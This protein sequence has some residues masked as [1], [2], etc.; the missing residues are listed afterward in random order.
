MLPH[1]SG[2][3]VFAFSAIARNDEFIRSV[4]QL[5]GE[6]VGNKSFT[7]HYHYLREDH[8]T[9]DEMAK[10]TGASVIA[11]TAK[12]LV[13][14]EPGTRFSLDLFV[15]DVAIQFARSDFIDYLF[16]ILTN[17]IPSR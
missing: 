9:F 7:D 10:K 15:L 8:L 16:D 1:L 6:L 5:G 14:I 17:L 12:D 11:T 13:R 3:R 4:K 2:L